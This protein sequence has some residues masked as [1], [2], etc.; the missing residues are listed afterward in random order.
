MIDLSVQP[1]FEESLRRVLYWVK[2]NDYKAYEPADG[3]SSVLFPLTIGRVFP[4]RILQQVVLRSPINV[5]PLLGVRPHDSAI[6]RGY[7]AWAHLTMCRTRATSAI[8]AEAVSCLAWLMSNRARGF[9]E[10]CWG[11][12]YNYATRSG[13][14][15]LG[16]PILIWTALIGQTFLDAYEVLGDEQ[17]RHVAESIGRWILQLPIEHTSSGSCLS[18]NA[19]KQESI[20]NSNAMGAAFLARLGAL[21][22]NQAVTTVAQQAMTYTCSRQL[23]DGGWFYG[24]EAKYHWFDNFHTGYNISALKTYRKALGDGSFDVQFWVGL[25]FFKRNFFEADGTPKYFHDQTY[26]I[27]I[28]CAAQAIDT[29]VSV[30]DEDPASLNLA[31]KVAEWTIDMLQARDGHFNYRHL[32]WITVTTPMLHWGQGTMAKALAQ[33]LHKIAVLRAE[34]APAP[35]PSKAAALSGAGAH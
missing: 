2:S 11:D 24:E 27:D 16:A 30:S 28:Q 25:D 6:A 8:E 32:G 14:R 35:S 12:P 7:L 29:L 15:P 17:Y 21:T 22:D 19:Y 9:D 31:V 34:V 10:F 4:M 13:R 33:L 5:R 3:N 1:R 23:T 26:P 20:H 18:Y